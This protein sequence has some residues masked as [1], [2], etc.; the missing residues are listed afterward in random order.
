MD[1]DSVEDILS[2]VEYDTKAMVSNFRKMAE[3]AI[4]NGLITPR[5]RQEIMTAF[6]RGLRGYT[7]FE[8]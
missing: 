6:K 7:Y 8:K 5:E 4:H 2:Y 1:G 3:Q